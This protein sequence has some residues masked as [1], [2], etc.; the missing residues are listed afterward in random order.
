MSSS[1]HYAWCNNPQGSLEKHSSARLVSANVS[2]WQDQCCTCCRHLVSAVAAEADTSRL[3]PQESPESAAAENPFDQQS[4]QLIVTIEQETRQQLLGRQAGYS[5]L[6]PDTSSQAADV[7]NAKLQ[8]AEALIQRLQ[9]YHCG[10][11]EA[12]RSA[13]IVLWKC[14][15]VVYTVNIYNKGCT[16][17]S[18]CCRQQVQ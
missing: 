3:Q 14:F 9:R 2:E 7:A 13:G 15:C 4:T 12:A 5:S 10:W 16:Y 1:C 11:T 8:Q 17:R 6:G 18:C